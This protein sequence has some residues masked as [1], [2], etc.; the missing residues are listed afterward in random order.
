MKNEISFFM[1][2][3][4]QVAAIMGITVPSTLGTVMMNL[5]GIVKVSFP[6]IIE[7]LITKNS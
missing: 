7:A 5:F 3:F 1:V 6:L 4:L 2:L